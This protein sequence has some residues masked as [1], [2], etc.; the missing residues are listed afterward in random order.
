MT[1]CLE[2]QYGYHTL[3][4]Y[5]LRDMDEN[6]ETMLPQARLQC[7]I[8]LL[9]VQPTPHAPSS[10]SSPMWTLQTV[11]HFNPLCTVIKIILISNIYFKPPRYVVLLGVSLSRVC[12]SRLLLF[13]ITIRYLFDI[14]QLWL[15]SHMQ[16][17]SGTSVFYSVKCEEYYNNNI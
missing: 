17:T 5:S 2:H 7:F 10:L 8:L 1:E 14:L 11:I 3:H 6:I 12:Q 9:K 13:V 15:V 4:Y 16:N